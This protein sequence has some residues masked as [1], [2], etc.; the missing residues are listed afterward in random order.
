MVYQ[1]KCNVAVRKLVNYQ[2]VDAHSTCIVH[3]TYEKELFVSRKSC[4]FKGTQ[5]SLG[6][7]IQRCD[8]RY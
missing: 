2:M 6:F 7:C 5:D 4:P 3:D 8:S 1:F